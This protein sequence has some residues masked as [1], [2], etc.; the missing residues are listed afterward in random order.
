MRCGIL[1][2]RAKIFRPPQSCKA[3]DLRREKLKRKKI[4]YK[5]VT[6]CNIWFRSLSTCGFAETGDAALNWTG[7]LKFKLS[8]GIIC[9]LLPLVAFTFYNNN[10]AKQVVKDKVSETYRNILRIFVE[11][12]D[13]MLYEM[14]IYLYGMETQDPDI[15]MIQSQPYLSNDYVITKVRLQQKMLRDVG[16]YNIID[17]IFLYTKQDL[18]MA[19]HSNELMTRAVID[20]HIGRLVEL[21]AVQNEH[22]WHLVLDPRIEGGA[23]LARIHQLNTGLYGCIFVKI[24]DIAEPLDILWNQGDIGET[25]ISSEEGFPLSGRPERSI[26]DLPITL[27]RSSPNVTTATVKSP[28]TGENYLVISQSSRLAG[29]TYNIIIPEK[30]M[31]SNI[32]FLQKATYFLPLGIVIVLLMFLVYLNGVLFKPLAALMRGMKKIAMG[33][34]DAR[35]EEGGALELNFLAHTFNTMAEELKNLK[36]DVYEEQLRARESE[37]KQLQAQISPHFYMNSLNIIYNVAALGDTESVKRMALHLADYFRFIMRTDR[38]TVTLAEELKHIENYIEIQKIR[39]PNKLEF[40]VRVDE[41]FKTCEIP[42]LIVQPFVENA[43]IHGF[44]NRKRL[45]RIS[46]AS[47]EAP[48]GW[49]FTLEV[50]DNGAGFPPE[51]LRNLKEGRPLEE[52]ERSRLGI[53]NVIHR[54][55]LHFNGKAAIEFDNAEEG[56]AMV[57]LHFPEPAAESGGADGGHHVQHSGR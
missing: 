20:D 19:T 8:V 48:P 33:K 35:L 9:V 14:N 55:K 30:T 26:G 21:E 32:P 50:R 37:L 24:V 16:F 40:E 18:I 36:I 3:A 34:L 25:V 51:V 6:S 11:Q 2:R 41:K 53:G 5:T 57:R 47:R 22:D 4:F 15:G 38:R 29:I 56:G 39:F 7:S 45:F 43:I 23:L 49:W 27:P 46:V 10:N 13:K 17:T 1:W 54:L 31:L 12:V 44:K 28:E 52:T 42:S